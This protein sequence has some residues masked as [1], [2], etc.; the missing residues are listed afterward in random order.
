[1]ARP[2]RDLGNRQER[3]KWGK[4]RRKEAVQSEPEI[5]QK[6]R[7]GERKREKGRAVHAAPSH[8]SVR[9]GGEVHRTMVGWDAGIQGTAKGEK[10]VDGGSGGGATATAALP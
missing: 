4:Q 5:G 2:R 7:E 6:E 8:P 1:M 3:G 10:G 9:R